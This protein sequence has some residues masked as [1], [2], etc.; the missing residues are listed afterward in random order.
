[1]GKDD[2]DVIVFKI[3]TY[4]YAVFKGKEIFEQIKYDKAIGKKYIDEEYL[5]RIYKLMSDEGLISNATFRAT[6]QNIYIPL[7]EEKDIEITAK[8]IHYLED[9]DKM[10]TVG[11]YLLENA[12]V[13]VNVAISA[14]I[15]TL[16]H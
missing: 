14:G 2:Y 9:N 16:F 6:W 3:L 8:G 15:E 10:K 12:D 7:F 1:M 11:K 13:I 5:S 4:L